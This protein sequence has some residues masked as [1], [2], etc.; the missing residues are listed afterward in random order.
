[1]INKVWILVSLVLQNHKILTRNLN[2]STT[3]R[4]FF[5]H[6]QALMAEYTS[7]YKKMKIS[8]TIMQRPKYD[9]LSSE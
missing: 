2:T 4:N 3:S 7:E 5:S 9:I 6:D 8:E 1:M